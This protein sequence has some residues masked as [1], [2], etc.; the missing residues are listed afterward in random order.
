MWYP[1]VYNI[2][3]DPREEID[4]AGQHGW[5]AGPALEAVLKYKET[6]RKYPNPPPPNLTKF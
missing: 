4:V 5:S 6:L 2:E 1:K 3:M